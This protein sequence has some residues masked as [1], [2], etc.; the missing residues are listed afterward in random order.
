MLQP[1][2]GFRPFHPAAEREAWQG[3]PAG[4]RR[5]L[6]GRGQARRGADW[7]A[8]PA[9]LFM[10]FRRTGNRDHYERPSFA[11]REALAELV[12]AACVEGGAP[13]STTS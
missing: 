1:H 13:C 8:L 4:L 12:L 7:P 3:L 9:T 2:A 11:R 6:L 10:D 5:A